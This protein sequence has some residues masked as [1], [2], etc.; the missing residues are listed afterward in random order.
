ME[1]IDWLKLYPRRPHPRG[2]RRWP[3]AYGRIRPMNLWICRAELVTTVVVLAVAATLLLVPATLDA[4]TG[5]KPA[6]A[7]PP[8]AAPPPTQA[9]TLLIQRRVVFR[10]FD[11]MV[12]LRIIRVL[13]PHSKTMY[14]VEVRQPRGIA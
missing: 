13:V 8:A 11:H 10:D 1:A 6:P 7:A 3:A 12:T 4:Q 9:A 14:F 5:S 2:G